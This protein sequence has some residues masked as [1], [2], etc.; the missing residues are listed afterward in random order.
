MADIAAIR[1]ATCDDIDAI[2]RLYRQ[3]DRYHA[4]LMP[5]ACE[6]VGG[7]AR[8][9][10]MVA[11]FVAEEGS[12]YLVA[13]RGNEIVGFL[14]IQERSH[15]PYPISRPGHFAMIEAAVVD[16]P[17]RGQGIGTALIDAAVGWA[18]DKGLTAMQLNV[19]TANDKARKFYVD[20]GFRPMMER[21]GL[22][23]AGDGVEQGAGTGGEGA[24]AQP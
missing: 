16:E 6:P 22:N 7:D 18:R 12:D 1:K 15:P 14:L 23:L 3:L 21:L 19:W 24:A 5:E 2:Q 13:Q 4:H 17:H 9:A 20:R 10:D 8:T 11:K